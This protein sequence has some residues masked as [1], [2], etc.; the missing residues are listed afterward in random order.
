MELYI[1][2]LIFS[3]AKASQLACLV[4]FKL[5]LSSCVVI[6]AK[7]ILLIIILMIREDIVVV[8]FF[9]YL[10]VQIYMTYPPRVPR[11]E[12]NAPQDHMPYITL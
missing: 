4:T 3:L 8:V 11:L 12:V 10:F 5:V 9:V 6:K 7:K 1:L 2:I